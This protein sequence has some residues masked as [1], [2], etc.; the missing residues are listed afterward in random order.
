MIDNL[1]QQIKDDK[2]TL[3]K[4]MQDFEKYKIDLEIE[5]GNTIEQMV[6]EI[7]EGYTDSLYSGPAIKKSDL[8]ISDNL[9]T[10]ILLYRYYKNNLRYRKALDPAEHLGI[11]RARYIPFPVA[12]TPSEGKVQLLAPMQTGS[13]AVFEVGLS[14]GDDV[15]SGNNTFNP[16]FS[17]SRLGVAMVITEK[18]FS[19]DAQIL[20]LAL[21]YDFNSYASIGV[22][23]NL[24]QGKSY[25]YYSFGINKKAFEQ[26]IKALAGLFD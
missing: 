21:T 15:V 16:A 14:F 20:G 8:R 10:A 4:C 5:K 3:R 11:F 26:L 22:G 19:S 2:D 12:G 25:P 1:N 13:P 7:A 9:H 17:V 23:R 18:L 24:A 6:D